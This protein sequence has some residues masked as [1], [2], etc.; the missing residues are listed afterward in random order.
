[1][2]EMIF[3]KLQKKIEPDITSQSISFTV[4]ED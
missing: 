1:M 2:F 4:D 3:G